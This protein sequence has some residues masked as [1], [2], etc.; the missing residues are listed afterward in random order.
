MDKKEKLKELE[1]CNEYREDWPEWRKQ[2]F[3]KGW[4]V[5]KNVVS[6]ERAEHYRSEFW[7]W[8]ESFK[9][10]ISRN[11]KNSWSENWPHSL[12]GIIH[13]FSFAHNQF[14]WDIR[15]EES[16]INIFK[17]IYQ[18]DKLLVSFDGGNVSKPTLE[19]RK[20][21]PHTDQGLKKQGFHCVQGFL[22]LQE[23]GPHDGGLIVLDGSHLSLQSYLDKYKSE[24]FPFWDYVKFEG[25]P[26]NLPMFKDCQKIKVC[27]ESGD[28]VLWDSR[29]IHYN[30]LPNPQKGNNECRMV[31]YTSYQP[32]YLARQKDID[33]KIE[34]FN[35]KSSTSHWAS[36][37]VNIFE[38]TST[39]QKY[40]VPN[41]ILSH[42][43][44][45]LAGLIP[46]SISEYIQYTIKVE[47]LEF[48]SIVD[49]LESENIF[50][51]QSWEEYIKA[52]SE[53]LGIISPIIIQ[54]VVDLTKR[55]TGEQI[56]LSIVDSSKEGS[57]IQYGYPLQDEN[58][59]RWHLAV[60]K[61]F[62]K[63][64]ELNLDSVHN[65]GPDGFGAFENE[66]INLE[67]DI[68]RPEFLDNESNTPVS[69]PP[70]DPLSTAIIHED[71]WKLE[72]GNCY[73]LCKASY[74]K[75]A[76]EF[77]NRSTV[78]PYH[79]ISQVIN[80]TTI[81]VEENNVY[82]K[83]GC[84][85]AMREA[86][87]GTTGFQSRKTF[88]VS[89]RGTVNLADILV[90]ID[91]LKKTTW[92]GSF[93][94]GFYRRAE[95]LPIIQLRKWI[96]EGHNIVITGHSLGG[97]VAAVL[98]A[99]L[100][101]EANWQKEIIKPRLIC[102]TFGQPLVA[103][104]SFAREL[105]N[106][107]K[108]NLGQYFHFIINKNDPVPKLVDIVTRLHIAVNTTL[109]NLQQQEYGK[110]LLDKVL[111]FL[112]RVLDRVL[113]PFRG[114]SDTA[115]MIM[116][117]IQQGTTAFIKN[118]S[119]KLH[120]FGQYHIMET[121]GFGLTSYQ[122]LNS[123]VKKDK[124]FLKKILEPQLEMF[125][126]PMKMETTMFNHNLDRYHRSSLCSTHKNCVI[127][128][129]A[130]TAVTLLDLYPKIETMKIVSS[131]ESGMNIMFR[132]KYVSFIGAVSFGDYKVVPTNILDYDS[133]EIE[134]PDL[135][136]SIHDEKQFERE[137]QTVKISYF[138][139]FNPIIKQVIKLSPDRFTVSHV[140]RIPDL[141]AMTSKIPPVQILKSALWLLLIDRSPKMSV[142]IEKILLKL[143]STVP[144][145][146]LLNNYFKG[147]QDKKGVCKLALSLL[148]R[149][150]LDLLF[151]NELNLLRS[152]NLLNPNVNNSEIIELRN[153]LVR[154]PYEPNHP[155]IYLESDLL[156]YDTEFGVLRNVLSQFLC[157][158]K[159]DPTMSDLFYSYRGGV[160]II[161]IFCDFIQ[162]PIIAR[163][164]SSALSVLGTP[165]SIFP[166][167]LVVFFEGLI[168]KTSY[169]KSKMNPLKMYRERLELIKNVYSVQLIPG[170]QQEFML[171]F[172]IYEH[173][174]Q[175]GITALDFS[176]I[177]NDS[178][179]REKPTEVYSL[180]CVMAI[181][182]LRRM[183]SVP[184][185]ILVGLVSQGKSRAVETVFGVSKSTG[186][187]SGGIND[188]TLVPGFYE[189]GG[190]TKVHVIDFPG[191]N[192]SNSQIQD[193]ACEA[194]NFPGLCMIFLDILT[195]NSLESKNLIEQFRKSSKDK[196][197]I[198]CLNKIDQW[199]LNLHMDKKFN[200]LQ[201]PPKQSITASPPLLLMDS[202]KNNEKLNS[203]PSTNI[204]LNNQTNNIE[205]ISNAIQNE[206]DIKT[207]SLIKLLDSNDIL[208]PTI[209]DTENLTTEQLE[210]I[211]KAFD[212][213]GKGT[214]TKLHLPKDVRDL[215]GRKIF[216][217]DWFDHD[218]FKKWE[219]WSQSLQKR[220]SYQFPSTQCGYA[221]Q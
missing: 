88:Y 142:R 113:K 81:E 65:V 105:K 33:T 124:K 116:N 123:W 185:I 146:F 27:C 200:Q 209:M 51:I 101:M 15:S 77:L 133:I 59:H 75:D 167:L 6:K 26:H 183:L 191:T 194:L 96:L 95:H 41:P 173:F 72:I 29:T 197:L 7:T 57:V 206:W 214:S 12:Q 192:D 28:F 203:N 127:S 168:G 160:N 117:F 216:E 11:D 60:H 68:P 119:I 151:G 30:C 156:K 199:Y 152:K 31:A 163:N 94:R 176:P 131:F 13:D 50:E 217:F 61:G 89:F 149:L 99:K 80:G 38:N 109:M 42:R 220:P 97:G 120:F 153:D 159:D 210:R 39:N 56:H 130:K 48:E 175:Q 171:E 207:R 8:I 219:N 2:L 136:G 166:L 14:L 213:D 162:S 103:D 188:R 17:E 78:R 189:A 158:V 148:S 161:D 139:T 53:S 141:L 93:H 138:S 40:V 106:F 45:L 21:W 102:I 186:L 108:D 154:E 128:H 204:N 82:P 115:Q 205:T 218:D 4:A 195:C 23:C 54:S 84:I 134:Y 178:M 125:K 79:S 9:T 157:Q 100:L 177:L 18:T 114:Y 129:A 198:I 83:Q 19:D 137:F 187:K 169:A 140:G 37:K 86:Q 58:T 34:A 118:L 172:S 52:I 174:L 70:P 44:K 85:V 32:A 62:Y 122:C 212:F 215:I 196:P 150:Q 181:H 92:A 66:R 211:Q 180:F 49:E 126:D 107:E 90:D 221:S 111:E 46:K 1:K 91:I 35:T 165:V 10:G 170:T 179:K 164:C 112:H 132:G 24:Q 145:F 73:Y 16:I 184:R 104:E 202:P 201:Q 190:E 76:I 47:P 71:D 3:L 135:L 20:P 74:E 98:A 87:V 182:E 5:V 193:I 22:N 155:V 143:V 144:P 69:N 43:A 67:K 208:I 121:G 110:E 147:D 55:W 63:I 64:L 36:E 25:D